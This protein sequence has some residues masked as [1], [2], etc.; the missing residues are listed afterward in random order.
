[1]HNRRPRSFRPRSNGRDFRRRSNDYESNRLI[2]GSY[3]SARDKNNFKPQQSVEKLLGSYKILAKE[4]ISLGD[5]TLS[6]NYLQHVDHFERIISERIISHKNL[7]QNEN[8]PQASNTSKEKNN[9]LSNN[10]EIDQDYIT[11]KKE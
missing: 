8:N 11:K 6:E 3:A 5:K 10:S 7:N 4:S 2:S 1:M 9:N